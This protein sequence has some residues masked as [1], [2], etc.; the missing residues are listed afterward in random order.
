VKL[1]FAGTPEIAVAPL[2]AIQNKWEVTGVLTQPDKTKGRGKKSVESPVKAR[3]LELGLEVFQPESLDE[4]FIES[5][6]KTGPDLLVVA[7]FGR[8][9]RK[10]FLD[11]FPLGGINLHP[12]LLP[13]YRGCSP[14][15]APILNGDSE[16]GITIQKLALKM[17]AGDILMQKKIPLGS[18]ETASGLTSRASEIG[19]ALLV[20]V[21]EAI[22]MNRINPVPQAEERATYCAMLTKED[23]LIDWCSSAVEIHRKV[24]AFDLWP[25]TYT[26]WNSSIL[27]ILDA[28]IY[29]GVETPVGKTAPETHRENKPGEVIGVDTKRGI[30]I[31]TGDGT[32]AVSRLQLQSKKPLDFK[33]FLNGVRDFQYTVLGG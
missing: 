24:R 23:G 21:I 17:D 13:L 2:V 25:G 22:E 15:S 28:E 7:A 4:Q 9:F 14:I 5:I 30:L 19:A 32:L 31:Q 3:A 33:S 29:T 27:R 6:I 26:H 16:T 1:F 12:S 8:I 20:E 11:I 18:D 10:S